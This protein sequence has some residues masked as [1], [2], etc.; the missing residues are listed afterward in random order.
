MGKQITE[1]WSYPSLQDTIDAAEHVEHLI[2]Q[3]AMLYVALYTITSCSGDMKSN[4]LGFGF[5]KF[6][7]SDP[8]GSQWFTSLTE[9]EV[10]GYQR[11]WADYDYS[12][13]STALGDDSV[14]VQ[15]TTRDPS[16]CYT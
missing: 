15:E 11:M 6:D 13:Y 10:R 14:S 3:L 7:T 16:N 12:C 8:R 5:D 2:S 1:T 4:I 9:D